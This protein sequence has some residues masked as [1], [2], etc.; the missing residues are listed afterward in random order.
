MKA[1]LAALLF[2]AVVP[3]AEAQFSGLSGFAARSKNFPC[4]AYLNITLQAK[5]PAMAVLWDVFGTDNTCVVRFLDTLK[6]R[7]HILEI[8]PFDNAALRNRTTEPSE[9]FYKMTKEQ[10]NAALERRDGAVIARVDHAIAEIVAFAWAHGNQNTNMLIS[11]GLEDNY[12]PRAFAVILERIRL[13]WPWLVVRAPVGG[14]GGKQGL[15]FFIERHGTKARGDVVNED[16]A[17][18]SL[19]QTKRFLDRNKLALAKFIWRPLH[20]GRTK[21]NKAVY[22]RS[23]REFEISAKDV[24]E[25]GDL[26][27]HY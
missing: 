22:P 20:Q 17:I 6:N 21:N 12:T 23:A 9:V 25:L 4:D 10:F 5:Y 2:L 8:H 16:G 24:K 27:S 14:S 26:L 11:T 13:Q 15:V 1:I 18:D 3:S 7:P 19:S